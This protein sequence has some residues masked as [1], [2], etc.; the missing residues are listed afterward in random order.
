VGDAVPLGGVRAGWAGELTQGEPAVGEPVNAP[1]GLSAI[2]HFDD[3]WGEP[4]EEGAV[5]VTNTLGWRDWVAYY[6]YWDRRQSETFVR[7]FWF[8]S[9][10][11]GLASLPIGAALAGGGFVFYFV[12]AALLR[13]AD[14]PAGP[15]P[16]I[17]AGVLLA[18]TTAV[19]VAAA[20]N[21]RERNPAKRRNRWVEKL[22][23]DAI[24]DGS[25]NLDCKYEL[26]IDSQGLHDIADI[27]KSDNQVE[28]TQ[29]TEMRVSWSAVQEIEV[30]EDY[31][32]L[33]IAGNQGF[34]VPVHAFRSAEEFRDFVKEARQFHGENPTPGCEPASGREVP[35][36]VTAMQGNSP[37]SSHPPTQ[38][39][40]KV[41]RHLSRARFFRR[42]R[43]PSEQF[44]R[45]LG[46]LTFGVIVF[47]TLLILLLFSILFGLGW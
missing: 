31:V 8:P 6:A 43:S 32:C 10:K 15:F 34:V 3:A 16:A 13:A 19:A 9:L 27:C 12:L 39:P 7:T 28:M 25:V 11:V 14:L 17:G 38:A 37:P 21:H 44:L 5:K 20:Y 2:E 35:A 23:N 29:R 46:H 45:L 30:V 18:L 33:I 36:E 4:G 22:V 24:S 47:A 41:E 26:T 40:D 1:A 42:A